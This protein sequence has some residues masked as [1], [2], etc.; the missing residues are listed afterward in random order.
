MIGDLFSKLKEARE[1][2]EEAKKK[3]YELPLVKN[4]LIKFELIPLRAYPGFERLFK[5]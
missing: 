3:L 2:I 4:G 5:K 1:K